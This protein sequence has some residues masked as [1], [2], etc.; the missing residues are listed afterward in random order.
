MSGLIGTAVMTAA[1]TAEM[2]VTGREPSLVPGRVAARLMRLEPSD[3]Q[4]LSR[5]SIGMHWAHGM[6]MGM[7]R[8]LIGRAG[9]EGPRATA[10]HFALM[11]GGDVMLY[12]SLGIADWPWRWSLPE[13]A[14][15][16]LHKGVY[17]AAT[18]ATYDRLA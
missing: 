15:D 3:D 4:A 2:R 13:L 12:K 5:I 9:L 7:V 6:T 18:G 1:Q 10:A 8:A 17:A 16:V 11:W 14:P